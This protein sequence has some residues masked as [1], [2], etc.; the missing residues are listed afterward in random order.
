M[1]DG[2][3]VWS[4]EVLSTGK[5]IVA[6]PSTHPSGGVYTWLTPWQTLPRWPEEFMEQ[7]PRDDPPPVAPVAP[8]MALP[9][10]S[11]S[12]ADAF[13]T[14]V[15]WSDILE[16]HGWTFMGQ[17]GERGHWC[18]PDK[19]PRAGIS[20]TTSAGVFYVFSTNTP[21]PPHV[22]LSKFATY[23]VLEHAGDQR[24]AARHLRALSQGR[25]A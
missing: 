20:G 6:P 5:Q 4:I 7:Y 24:Q 21:F 16:P 19:D 10:D 12:I 8:R 13:N 3:P 25:A 2:T 22:G 17:H 23:A 9:Q 11:G 18:R 14:S 1:P 15:S